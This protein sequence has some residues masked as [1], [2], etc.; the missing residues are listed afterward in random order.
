MAGR[1][2]FAPSGA[3]V[4][5]RFSG[6][7]GEVRLAS[8]REAGDD[9]LADFAL[10]RDSRTLGRSGVNTGDCNG[11]VE[12]VDAAA[13]GADC[14]CE[15][16]KR[17]CCG[18]STKRRLGVFG[19]AGTDVSE[20]PCEL[21]RDRNLDGDRE[22]ERRRVRT[23]DVTS[24]WCACVG[25]GSA[26]VPPEFENDIVQWNARRSEPLRGAS[27]PGMST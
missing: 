25:D 1:E 3:A 14:G 6:L 13:G 22:S 19:D 8:W 4:S 21:V 18:V 17:W 23:A 26:R 20:E 2:R 11:V 12:F 9:D 5:V 10:R 7:F 15:A 27:R 24:I 16:K